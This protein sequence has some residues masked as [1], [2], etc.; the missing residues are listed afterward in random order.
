MARIGKL[1]TA[2]N[3]L[4]FWCPGCNEAHGIALGPNGWRWNGDYDKPVFSPSV[5]VRGGHFAEWYRP[6]G[7]C[8]C[9]HNAALVAKGEQPVNFKCRVCHSFVGGADGAKPG[10]IQFL[11][12]STHELAGQTVELPNYPFGPAT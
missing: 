7:E 1:R 11:A 8:W 12:D 4:L 2:T 3:G 10:F 5:L 9:T 6:G